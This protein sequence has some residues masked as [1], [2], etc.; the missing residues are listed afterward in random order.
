[1]SVT[2]IRDNTD[3]TTTRVALDFFFG[4]K[5][6]TH[7]PQK[8]PIRAKWNPIGSRTE[9]NA[10]RGRGY[11]SSEE[12]RFCLWNHRSSR[13]RLC[14]VVNLLFL[15]NGKNYVFRSIPILCHCWGDARVPLPSSV[16]HQRNIGL[17]TQSKALFMFI[18]GMIES[19]AR[20]YDETKS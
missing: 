4:L 14:S 12:K 11:M 7:F 2:R 8:R 13:K 3:I 17:S 5:R 19:R 9:A 16:T 15:P 20:T 18:S 10:R 1:M 6:R